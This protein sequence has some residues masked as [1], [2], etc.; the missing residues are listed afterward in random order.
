MACNNALFAALDIIEVANQ[1]QLELTDIAKV[2]FA[3]GEELE[4]TWLKH[5]IRYHPIETHWDGIARS[6]LR[7]D[8]DRYQGELSVS[9][10][11]FGKKQGIPKVEKTIKAWLDTHKLLIDRWHA[12]L[13]DLRASTPTF[14][15]YSVS[16][17]ELREVVTMTAHEE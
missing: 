15:T 8:L 11:L 1:S 4:L 2:Y 12:M 13:T 17:R 16:T 10:L 9:V 5:E 14:T 3:L 6:A 7:D